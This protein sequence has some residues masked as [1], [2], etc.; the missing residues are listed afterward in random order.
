M[1]VDRGKEKERQKRHLNDPVYV[2][3]VSL[4]CH[5]EGWREKI[6]IIY[7]LIIVLILYCITLVM[8]KCRHVQ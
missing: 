3:R 5:F 2:V 1:T 4:V 6:A 7:V 8:Q